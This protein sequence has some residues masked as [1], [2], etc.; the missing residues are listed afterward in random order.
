MMSSAG[1]VPGSVPNNEEG[2]EKKFSR[3][4]APSTVSPDLISKFSIF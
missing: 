1:E 2:G 4:R 3:V